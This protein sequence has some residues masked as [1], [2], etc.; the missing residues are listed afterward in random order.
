V[1]D[2]LAYSA[3]RIKRAVGMLFPFPIVLVDV[4]AARLQT[5]PGS[6][7]GRIPRKVHEV[8]WEMASAGSQILIFND[9][10]VLDTSA[11]DLLEQ[12]LDAVN[13]SDALV[14]CFVRR[15]SDLDILDRFRG[16]GS[17]R[18]LMLAVWLDDDEG[19]EFPASYRR[20][21]TSDEL[22]QC[23]VALATTD[24]L[25]DKVNRYLLEKVAAR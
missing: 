18:A 11:G 21:F 15:P 17:D 10:P 13:R 19:G 25:K 24:Y 3:G 5:Y 16:A 4:A 23:A 1:K 12:R 7:A 2:D 22:S 20:T 6:K 8:H 14:V 9:V